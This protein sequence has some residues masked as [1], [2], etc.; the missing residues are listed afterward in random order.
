M[1]INRQNNLFA[2]EDWKVAYKAYTKIN[3]QAYDFDTIRTSLVDY[4]R[5][6]YPENFNDYIDSS[7]FIAIIDLLAY[8]SQS[9]AFRMDLNSREN[10]LET[11]E[12]RDS[13]FKLARMLGYNPK[14]NIPASGLMKVTSIR[15]N[16]PISDSLGTSLSGKTIYWDDSNNSQSYEQFITILNSAMSKTN[17]FSAPVKEGIINDI[18]AELYQLNTPMN[19]P[20]TYNVPIS[21][22]GVKRNFN[23]VNPDLKDNDSFF[24]RHPDPINPFHMIYRN[25]SKGLSSKD[26]GFF[27][28]L[29]QGELQS[30]D[31]NFTTPVENR[32]E[33][34]SKTDINEDDVYLQEI[35]ANGTVKNKWTSIPNTIGQTLNY[36][37]SSLDT[38]NL[39][40][41]E[42]KG[43]QGITLRF[44]DGNFANI[45]NGIFRLWHR[46]SSPT[47]F[48]IKPNDAKNKSVT[49]PYKNEDGKDF[50]LTITFDLMEP[51]RNSSPSES[52]SAIKERAP[53]V[54]YTQNRMVSAQDYNVFPQS[55]STNITKMKAINRTHSGH[56]RY[57]D[58]ND[59]T[60]TYKSVETFAND[61]FLYIDDASESEQVF[62]NDTSTPVEITAS[63]L[64]N[65]LKTLS[66]NNFV[67]YSMRNLYTDPTANG[68]V[69]T[70]KYTVADNV[71]WNT[72]P[73]KT[74][75]TSGYLTEQFTT[76]TT[77]VLINNPAIGTDIYNTYGNK[78]LPLKENCFL[79]FVNPSNTSE[80]IWARATK[81]NNNGAL[82]SALS[83]GVGPWTLSDDVPT[84]YRLVEVIPSLRKQFST[85]EASLIVSKIKA[86][87]S[88]ALGYDL[89]KDS[90]YL[91]DSS[92]I[93]SATKTNTFS[94]DTDY[95][96]NDSWLLFMEYSA[97]D[98]KN[99]KYNLITRGFDYVIQSKGD[100]KFYNTK[101]IKVLD[102]NNRSKR[103][104]VIFT[105]VN[106]RPGETESFAWTGS[107]WNNETIG[108]ST[109]PRGRV[110]DIPLRT[111]DT[112]WEDV[113]VSWVSNFGILRTDVG[114][115]AQSYRDRNL[116]VNDAVVA[117][118]TYSS[119]GGVSSETNVVVQP[120]TGKISSMP[121]YIDIN[122]NATTF[123]SDIVD[124]SGAVAFVMYKQLQVN[125]SLSTEQFIQANLGD[126]S[127]QA[128]D[129]NGIAIPDNFGRILFTKWD[130]VTRTGTLRYTDL[131]NSDYLY[132]SDTSGN[133]STDKLNVYYENNR[134]KL[135]RPIVW[136]VVD[137]FKEADGYIDARKIK[138]APVDTDG[139]LVPDY[140][141]QFAEFADKTDLVFF[142]YYTDFD[143]Y[144]YNRPFEGKIADLRNETVLDISNTRNILSPG[145]FNRQYILNELDW[146][147]VKTK[148]LAEQFE[149]KSNA[150]GLVIYV[151]E[152][153]K[154]YQL[155]PIGTSITET[156]LIEAADYFTRLGRGQTQN[157]LSSIKE[158]A[159][160]KW[161]HVAP[162][163]VRIDP[164]IS[165]VIE[166]VMLTTTY[167]E[168]VLKWQNRQ[169]SEFPLE[170]T[171]NQL[172]I[173][174][175]KLNDYKNA[176]DSLV[177]RSA[178]FKLLFGNKANNK[179]KAKF[180]VI[181]LSDQFSDNELKTRI[182]S[183]INQYFNVKNWDFGETFYFTELSTYIHQQLG[184]AIGSI[185]ILPKNS[186]G[187]FGEMFQVK[188]E[189]N[190]LFLST[191]TVNDIEIISRLDSKTLSNTD[192]EEEIA[193]GSRYANATKEAGPYAIE[194]YYPLYSSKEI[195][196]LAGNGTTHTHNFF[197]QTF[198]MPN[199]VTY[200]HGNY[201]ITDSATTTTDTSTG[202]GS[203][204]SSNS[205]GGSG[206]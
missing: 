89:L 40:A 203:S 31:F 174:F 28:M 98:N 11:A 100:L 97:M 107:A 83:T 118:N 187:K 27:V 170:P 138:V 74:K 54:F 94:I 184:S 163:D 68:S 12:S 105:T 178:K 169:D 76:G 128:T 111:R 8:L 166:M 130:S 34:I 113:E 49:V 96:G 23:I 21:V 101:S 29:K 200:Y 160:I 125:G 188:S 77:G 171:S 93:T 157:T 50:G 4:I 135:S 152:E 103:D 151:T 48:V 108:V 195:A 39:Y 197:G 168:E 148:A 132:L 46:V 52:L 35:N 121:S 115:T 71:L 62:V 119:S 37:S 186:T 154:T 82:S 149:N 26:T 5:K 158:N 2:A 91:I 20:I 112:T 84:G 146:I 155:T 165:N 172:N 67:Y 204:G 173:E 44:S 183:V 65:K 185:V 137:V 159:I 191:A 143:G 139:D 72:Q 104:S 140:P 141:L 78:L 192:L 133:I 177:F 22:N 134:D 126:T 194:G 193:I 106:T 58:I 41:I 190:E 167:Y 73:S 205:S 136:D 102:S 69:N 92:N 175:E 179:L 13:V 53:Q 51:I 66:L 3:F 47:R 7:E 87:E 15:T 1:A 206:Y 129:K 14:R 57:I 199:G 110:V 156:K 61:A 117:L 124:D 120:N 63:I 176:T 196:E 180:R 81:I 42:N 9:L 16:E 43:N 123:G 60:G 80:F 75:G 99:Y 164:S 181:K 202:T 95:R 59:P 17:R 70:F 18:P 182:I 198:Y 116:F 153:D 162:N 10:F 201:Q 79:K 122:F 86:E 114:A 19:A 64:T 127:P 33:T 90:W 45:P 6:N 55:Q 144:R 38:R 88:F 145:S 150:S 32:Q 131:Q 30:Q 24:E 25:D 161:N 85:T 189:P 147:V 109:V 36:T 56:S 142:E